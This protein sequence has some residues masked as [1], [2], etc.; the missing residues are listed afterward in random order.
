MSPSPVFYSAHMTQRKGHVLTA[1]GL[2]WRTKAFV[3][4]RLLVYAVFFFST[5][6]FL[7]TL[8]WLLA[9]AADSIPIQLVILAIAFGGYWLARK[10][11]RRYLTYVGNAPHLMAMVDFIKGKVPPKGTRLVDVSTRRVEQQFDDPSRIF[12]LETLL[13]KILKDARNELITLD[14]HPFPGYQRLGKA[15]TPWLWA[16]SPY[17]TNALIGFTLHCG[18]ANVWESAR[19]GMVL[20]AQRAE[21]ITQSAIRLSIFGSLVGLAMVGLLML[22]TW[23]LFE[24]AWAAGPII[25]GV[26]LIGV[27]RAGWVIKQA[28]YG[29]FANGYMVSK[30]LGSTFELNDEPDWEVRL[31]DKSKRFKELQMR[32]ENFRPDEPP[33]EAAES[34]S[35][36]GESKPGESKPG[37]SKIAQ[38]GKA[39]T[40]TAK[41]APA[42]VVAPPKA[43]QPAAEKS[44]PA[45]DAPS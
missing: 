41:G 45:H 36:P 8:F 23:S 7:G 18:Q 33:E 42:K 2:L 35:K 15:A 27:F 19:L 22:P 43:A 9:H 34:E 29:P 17:V 24:T 44:S 25:G 28:L 1:L 32:A 5:I 14:F 39:K 20:F 13:G 40:D 10:Q 11:L 31:E 30:F 26:L 12:K 16:S 4:P 37:E 21:Q 6:G 3:P 38:P